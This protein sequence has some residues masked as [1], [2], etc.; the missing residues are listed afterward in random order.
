MASNQRC[1]SAVLTGLL[2]TTLNEA[3]ASVAELVGEFPKKRD[4]PKSI[5]SDHFAALPLMSALGRLC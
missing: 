2:T 5:R 3:L 1:R 4:A